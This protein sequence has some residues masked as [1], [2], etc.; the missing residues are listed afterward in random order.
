M[1]NHDSELW[2]SK[3][4]NAEDH[5]NLKT[6]QEVLGTATL[7]PRMLMS[8]SIPAKRCDLCLSLTAAATL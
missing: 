3:Y 4:E 7:W 6:H 1:L 5:T 8:T 2:T